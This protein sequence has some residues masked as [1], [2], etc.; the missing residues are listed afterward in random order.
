MK[1]EVCNLILN[2]M[3]H[4][5]RDVKRTGIKLNTPHKTDLQGECNIH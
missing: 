4:E 2:V 3:L 1:T 5:W